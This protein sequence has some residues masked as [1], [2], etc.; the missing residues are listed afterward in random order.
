M[1]PLFYSFETIEVYMKEYILFLQVLLRMLPN[2]NEHVSNYE[3]T[4]ITKFFGLH[5]ITPS[6]GQK[7]CNLYLSIDDQY[8]FGSSSDS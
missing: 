8:C 2:Y 5:R 7:V 3:N 6:S 4:L 1:L